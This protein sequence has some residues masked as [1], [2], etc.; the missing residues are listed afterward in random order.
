MWN[1]REMMAA[2]GAAASLMGGAASAQ[3][4]SAPAAVESVLVDLS[5]DTGPLRHIWSECVGSDRAAF[6]LRQDWRHDA[7]R[8]HKELGVKRVRFH[9]IF[10]DDDIGVAPKRSFGPGPDFNFQNVDAVYDG[11]MDIGLRPYVELSFMPGRLA[12]GDQDFGTYHAN[13]TP[14]KSLAEWQGLIDQFARHLIDRYG[15]AEVRQWYFEVWNE[16]DLASFWTGTQAE[17]FELYKVTATTLKAVDPALKVG[18]PSTSRVQWIP[19]FLSYCADNGLPVDFV[20]THVYAGDDQKKLFG[21]KNKYSQNDV[22]PEAM[23]MARAQ[24]AASPFKNAELFLGEWSSDSPAMIAHIIEGCLPY[25]DGMSYWQVSKFEEFVIPT[26]VLKEGDNGWGLMSPGNI[27]RPSFNTFK[28]LN[29][30]GGRRVQAQGPVLATRLASGASAIML[31]NLAEVRQPAGIPGASSDRKVV[32]ASKR[33]QVTL[34]G[35]RPGQRVRI[36]YVDQERASPYPAWRA[37]GSPLYPSRDQLSALRA[38]A[39]LPPPVRA[40]LGRER[41]LTI[42]L[43]PEGVALIELA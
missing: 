20:S 8:A 12:S 39:E 36:S 16:P 15:A 33:F 5:A 37:M 10:G 43:P 1:R 31:W 38:A 26:Y 42:D 21:Q 7:A 2:T 13:I 35:A 17:Y 34:K 4:T 14:P 11:L 41:D 18:G 3:P 27:A 9:G 30:L 22:V 29:R 40:R 24:L 32:G 23:K 6:T 28:L 19:Q 25:C